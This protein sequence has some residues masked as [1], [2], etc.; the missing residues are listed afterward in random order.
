MKK[1]AI[2]NASFDEHLGCFGEFRMGD[3]ICRNYC[4]L[5]I[6]C[7]IEREHAMRM[8]LIEDLVAA[9]GMLMKIQ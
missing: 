7:I 4:A 3:S 8:E 6:R 1:D 9:D 5:R 2:E